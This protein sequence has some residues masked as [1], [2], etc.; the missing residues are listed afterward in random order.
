MEIAARE[1]DAEAAARREEA[2]AAMGWSAR[3]TEKTAAVVVLV[4]L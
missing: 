1:V 4:S 2:V 3:E